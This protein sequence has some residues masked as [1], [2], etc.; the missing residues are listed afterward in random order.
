VSFAR[1]RVWMSLL[2]L[3]AS[4]ATLGANAGFAAAEDEGFTLA[5]KPDAV[6]RAKQ[7]VLFR[8]ARF[9][10][11]ERHERAEAARRAA[12]G[13]KSRR[14]TR[15]HDAR[16]PDAG[17]AL[18]AR[19][20][21]PASPDEPAGTQRATRT[22]SPARTSGIQTVPNNYLVNDKTG[23]AVDAGQAEQQIAMIGNFGLCAWNDGQGFKA[24]AGD[25]QKAGYTTDGGLTWIKVNIPKPANAY[26]TSDPVVTV[27]EKTGEFYYCGLI[28]LT[29]GSDPSTCTSNGI[30]VV[31][32]TFPG[33]VFT[34]DTP[35]IA[36][37]APYSQIAF[38]K[39]WMVADSSSN[40][41]Y[42]TYTAFGSVADTIDFVRSTNN[43]VTWSVPQNMNTSQ[44]GWVQGSRPAVG[45]A[46]EV[47]VVWSEIGSTADFMRLR[48]S[49]TAGVSFQGQVTAGSEY[50]NYGTGGPGFN[51]PSGITFPAITVDR[52]FGNHRGRVYVGWNESLNFYNAPLSTGGNKNE[53]ESN[54][55]TG[56]A[57]TFVPGQTLRGAF[58]TT[59]DI[60]FFSFTASQGTSYIFW[61]DS[62]PSALFY[63]RVYC[64][65]GT[66]RL[67]HTGE[68]FSPSGADGVGA[69][70]YLIV[71]T[72]PA[73][74]TYYLR[75]NW[76][77]GGGSALGGYRI[78]SGTDAYNP[79]AGD[80]ARD[81]RDAMLA[82][83]DGGTTW[84]TQ[85]RMNDDS[86]WYDNWLPELAV[87]SEGYV[88]G[89]WFDFRD[90]VATCA[91]SSH[92]YS[93]RS[94][95]GGIT[96]VANQRITNA[97]TNWSSVQ[98][99]IQPNQG[100][101]NAIYAGDDLA[102]AWSDGRLGDADVFA[103]R[104]L[105][106]QPGMLCPNDTTVRAGTTVNLTF[107]L[108][109]PNLVFASPQNYALTS[110]RSWGATSG[111]T[112]VPAGGGNAVVIPVTLPD[113]AQGANLMCFRLAQAN[114]A[115]AE[116]CCVV[117]NV[118]QG[119]V[120]VDPGVIRFALHGVT[121]NP[122]SGAEVSIHFSLPIS[123]PATLE[124]LDLSGRRILGRD[125]GGLG[126]GTHTMS[127]RETRWLPAGMYIVR[128]SQQGRALTTKLAVVR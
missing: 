126:A 121:P 13:K 103:T 117:L 99:N 73:N 57:T 82:W 54:N 60:D 63:M 9:E 76:L 32:A 16:D 94:V 72:A 62:I 123:A 30:A 81:M 91:G 1:V 2:A 20:M 86:G 120:S 14:A 79:G 28:D 78:R 6:M 87:S 105:A 118:T 69:T 27:N 113:T 85:V 51:R 106:G 116:S 89:T 8:E 18:E 107:N 68:I 21:T 17:D 127:L 31:R 47:Y 26:W 119:N 128:L 23:D 70:P 33:G 110:Q 39:E 71:W 64:T 15:R 75:M 65:D 42:L 80:R 125:V 104:V 61:C 55:T 97:I 114:G 46:G 52:S 22:T 43:G 35:R 29:C 44:F 41:L 102:Y 53:V 95:D 59:A 25:K 24:P 115:R 108:S 124:I 98:S 19:R 111:S 101:Y 34:W 100:D 4:A 84:S 10:A 77:S 50:S 5:Q 7:E 122:S 66:T 58:G 49:T 96:W 12:A 74:G 38:D 92:I 93:T 3:A 45:P 37:Q 112:T 56:T 40:N 67:A 36:V 11:R 88:Y 109:N 90:A 83:S 48:K